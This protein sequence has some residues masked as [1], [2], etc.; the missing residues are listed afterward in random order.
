M[1]NCTQQNN[2]C[3]CGPYVGLFAKKVVEN[4]KD[5]IPL[6]P[7]W[8]DRGLIP[9]IRENMKKRCAY[10]VAEHLMK[11]EGIKKMEEQNSR[12]DVR[13]LGRSKISVMF[14]NRFTTFF[15]NKVL[16]ILYADKF[17]LA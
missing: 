3:D 12:L 17:F 9:D 10:I 7:C 16:I 8:V 5:G 11:E 1:V 13:K 4:I 14:F 6:A 15:L 2:E